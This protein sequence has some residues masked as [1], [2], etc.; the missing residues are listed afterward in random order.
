MQTAS[1][2]L[3]LTCLLLIFH[4]QTSLAFQ[5][6]AALEKEVEY[7]KAQNGNVLHEVQTA[8][9]KAAYLGYLHAAELELYSHKEE[10]LKIRSERLTHHSR[11]ANV[12]R[13]NSHSSFGERSTPPPLRKLCYV[14]NI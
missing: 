3:L 5:H 8:N 13:S 1:K 6:N 2:G 9:R 14:F 11:S 7:L 4:S 12:I 10:L